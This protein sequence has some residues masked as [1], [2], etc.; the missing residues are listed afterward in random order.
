MT[1]FVNVKYPAEHP[2]VVRVESALAAAGHLKKQVSG[3]R[4]LATL[5]LAAMVAAATVVAYQVMDSVAEGHLLV[6]WIAL[7]AIA[8]AALALFA[9]VARRLAARAVQSLNA[10]SNA[11]AQARA[12]VRL[13]EAARADPRVMAD[14][15]VAIARRENV[16]DALEAASPTVPTSSQK[17][18]SRIK[19]DLGRVLRQYP[20]YRI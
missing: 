4:G 5:L 14:L 18:A 3:A 16:T 20:S 6:I 11:I 7:W 10:W 15:Q 1:S 19:W 8:F 2:G 13:W 9:G 17:P 12:D